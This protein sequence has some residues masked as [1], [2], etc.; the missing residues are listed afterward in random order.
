MML[1]IKKGI[2]TRIGLIDVEL[3]LNLGE[4][5][6]LR[7]E[8][9]SGKSTLFKYLKEEFKAGSFCEQEPL[10]AM[11]YYTGMDLKNILKRDGEDFDKESFH[12]MLSDLNLESLLDKKIDYFSGG[13]SQCLKLIIFLSFKKDYYFFD[14]PFTFLDEKKKEYFFKKFKEMKKNQKGVFI[15]DHLPFYDDDF[16]SRVY[17]LKNNEG[18]RKIVRH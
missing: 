17:L 7:G 5:I 10:G 4:A 15:I 3:E 2:T 18:V 13:E 16:F 14:E 12:S 1:S 11:P 9:G 6:W 8:N